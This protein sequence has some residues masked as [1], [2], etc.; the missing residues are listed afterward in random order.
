MLLPKQLCVSIDS[1]MLMNK[2]RKEKKWPHF[3]VGWKTIKTKQKKNI[4]NIKIKLYKLFQSSFYTVM[5][6]Y[7]VAN[8]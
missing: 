7:F 5:K 3:H 6:E 8:L 2:Y 4:S 1:L